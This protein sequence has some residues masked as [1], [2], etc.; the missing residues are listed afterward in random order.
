MK[1]RVNWRREWEEE[2]RLTPEEEVL[3][4]KDAEE[5]AHIQEDLRMLRLESDQQEEERQRKLRYAKDYLKG[6]NWTEAAI[7][8]LS[9]VE[10]LEVAGT[11]QEYEWAEGIFDYDDLGFGGTEE[12]D[13]RSF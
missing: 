7:W 10:L 4:R 13:P 5:L 1:T 9:D 3:A 6:R 8:A 11:E 2:Q 12:I